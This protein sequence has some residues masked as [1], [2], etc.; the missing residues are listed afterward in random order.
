M[1][2]SIHLCIQDIKF[3]FLK[4]RTLSHVLNNGFRKSSNQIRWHRF[5]I[6]F[7]TIAHNPT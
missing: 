7:D 2:F 5:E 4:M 3:N 1:T 6:R